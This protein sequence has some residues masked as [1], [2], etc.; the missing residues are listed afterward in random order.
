MGVVGAISLICRAASNPFITG[1]DRSRMTKSGSS[2][3]TFSMATAP[4]GASAQTFQLGFCSIQRRRARRIMELS[5]TM[6][7]LLGTQPTFRMPRGAL[8]RCRPSHQGAE[9]VGYSR[10]AKDN[11]TLSLPSLFP[12]TGFTVPLAHI[13]IYGVRQYKSKMP[14]SYR[15]MAGTLLA[16]FSNHFVSFGV[17]RRARGEWRACPTTGSKAISWRQIPQITEK[18]SMSYTIYL[19]GR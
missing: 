1:I 5:S 16:C 9:A 17:N 3:L 14:T 11:V 18:C 13:M 7:I 6:R 12:N 15:S 2:S 8:G 10:K 19:I 4:F